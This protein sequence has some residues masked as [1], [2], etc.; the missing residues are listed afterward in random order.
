[1]CRKC[2]ILDCCWNSVVVTFL[3]Q[4]FFFFFSTLRFRSDS[5]FMF[6]F[7]NHNQR[8]K[9]REREKKSVTSTRVQENNKNTYGSETSWC[10]GFRLIFKN[11]FQLYCPNGI[12]P[13]GNLGCLS[14]GKPAATVALS[15]QPTVHA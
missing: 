12:S 5:K 11:F 14:W 13:V 8:G 2:L 15:N 4:F 10:K 3:R 6:R 9:E 7:P 1:M